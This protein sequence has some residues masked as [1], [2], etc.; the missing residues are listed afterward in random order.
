VDHD[1][2]AASIAVRCLVDAGRSTAVAVADLTVERAACTVATLGRRVEQLSGGSSSWPEYG[3]V[4]MSRARAARQR[5]GS[6]I[7]KFASIVP[8]RMVE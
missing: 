7:D 5:G 8:H 6:W 4:Q 3:A 2:R 1:V